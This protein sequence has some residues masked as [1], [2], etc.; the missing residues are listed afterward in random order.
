MEVAGVSYKSMNEDIQK[1]VE[2][3]YSAEFQL[4]ALRGVL[5]RMK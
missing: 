1:G 5:S 4:K 2:M 3:G